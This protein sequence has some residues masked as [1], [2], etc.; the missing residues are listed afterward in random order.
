M[1]CTVISG[2]TAL[3]STLQN[4]ASLSVIPSVTG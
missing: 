1:V 3:F 4:S 2:M